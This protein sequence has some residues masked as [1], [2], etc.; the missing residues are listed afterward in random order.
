MPAAARDPRG[1]GAAIGGAR[2]WKQQRIWNITLVTLRETLPHMQELAI[3]VLL[4]ALQSSD[5]F[6]LEKVDGKHLTFN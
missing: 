4:F 6:L 5:K 2:P 1:A 3:S